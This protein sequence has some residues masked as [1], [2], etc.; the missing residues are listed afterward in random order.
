MSKNI[1]KTLEKW[2]FS[3]ALGL[4]TLAALLGF[5]VVILPAFEKA[6]CVLMVSFLTVLYSTQLKS[7]AKYCEYDFEAKVIDGILQFIESCALLAVF[8]R[9]V[10]EPLI[11]S[12]VISY[13]FLFSFIIGGLRI[14]LKVMEECDMKTNQKVTGIAFAVGLMTGF[15]CVLAFAVHAPVALYDLTVASVPVVLLVMNLR[16]IPAVKKLLERHSG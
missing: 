1:L 11:V 3:V 14:A 12:P 10:V 2:A 16:E 6:V 9:T 15:W 8:A 4:T 13:L 5:V 7:F